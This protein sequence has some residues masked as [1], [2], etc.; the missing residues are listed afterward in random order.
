LAEDHK[1]FPAPRYS[2]PNLMEFYNGGRTE[3]TSAF[4]SPTNIKL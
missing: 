3:K 1:N 2:T 4:L